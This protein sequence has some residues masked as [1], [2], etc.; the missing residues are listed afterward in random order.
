M[1]IRYFF[2]NKRE[3]IPSNTAL[4]VTL[5]SDTNANSTK[6]TIYRNFIVGSVFMRAAEFRS[7]VGVFIFISSFFSRESGFGAIAFFHFQ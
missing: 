4:Y 5:N 3:G 7:V 6:S 1:G 2:Q